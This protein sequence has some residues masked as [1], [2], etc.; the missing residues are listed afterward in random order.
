MPV[1]NDGSKDRE[2]NNKS[3]RKG[4]A[5]GRKPLTQPKAYLPNAK[6]LQNYRLYLI[7]IPKLV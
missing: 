4:L 2:L 6:P 1:P 7:L 5:F 3:N